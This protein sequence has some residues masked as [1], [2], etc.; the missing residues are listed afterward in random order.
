MPN[1]MDSITFE[2]KEL[3]NWS[4]YIYY[5]FSDST[6]F[7]IEKGERGTI[8]VHSLTNNT[9]IAFI[10]VYDE[11]QMMTDCQYRNS[12]CHGWSGE[13]CQANPD[14]YGT[15]TPANL[16]RI[17]KILDIPIYEGWI[18]KDFYLFG[19]HYRSNSIWKTPAGTHTFR[20]VD[21]NYGCL[22][23]VLFPV[24]IVFN[25]LMNFGIMGTIKEVTVTPIIKR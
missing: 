18:S 20:F 3:N 5:K 21:S 19:K 13:T 4:D 25:I 24:F 8:T 17:D 22:S 1:K 2:G 6:F 14:K 11:G 9:K 12:D 7:R 23:V 15:F 16:G 10:E